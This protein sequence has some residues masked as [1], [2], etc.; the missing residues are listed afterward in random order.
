MPCR[1]NQAFRQQDNT[2]VQLLDAIRF[3]CNVLPL[4]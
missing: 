4:A 3:G 2:F 1:A